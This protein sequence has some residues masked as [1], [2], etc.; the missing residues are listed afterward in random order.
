MAEIKLKH[1]ARLELHIAIGRSRHDTKWKN[2]TVTWTQLLEKVSETVR[3]HE[4]A[5][6]YR[7]MGKDDQSQIK[8]I[9]GFVG[10]VLKDGRRKNGFVVSRSIVTLDADFAPADFWDDVQ[11]LTTYAVAAYST[12]K[13]TP[14]HPRL[15]FLIPLNR[16]VSP[17]EYEAIARYI[18]N[19]LGIDYFDDTTYEPTRLMYWP[20]TS[21]D[22]D[23]FFEYVDAPI[24][25][26]DTVLAKYTDWKDTSNWPESSRCKGLRR[27]DAEKQGDPLAKTGLIGAFCRTYT[28]QDAIATFL[29]DA[30]TE[31][32]TPGRYTYVNG[33]TAAGLVVYEDKF[34]YSNHA[35]DPISG[36]L[37]NAFDLVRIHKFGEADL[38]AKEG[39]PVNKLPSWGKMMELAGSDENIRQTIG[40]EKL[41]RAKEDFGEEFQTTDD[42]AWLKKLKTNKAGGY[43]PTIGNL[44]LILQN[45]ANLRAIKGRDLFRDRCAVSGTLPW[46]REGDYWTDIDD[47]GLRDYIE[48]VYG[49]EAKGKLLDALALVFEEKSY[50]PVKQFIES[51][52]WDGKPR[53]ET[54]LIDYLGA[55]DSS[56]VRAV[57]RKTLVAAIARIYSPGC[58]FDYMLTIVGPQGH[59]KTL[60]V[61]KLAGEWFSNSI[62]EI[63]GKE[64]YEAL[65]GAWIVE[66]GELAA[67]KK[68]D[69]DAIK[70]YISKTEDTYRKAYAR[71]V[72]IN[73]RRCVFIGT[74]N[75]SAFLED[76]TGNRRFWVVDTDVKKRT[77]VPWGPNG[78]TDDEVHQ[79]WAEALELYQNGENIMELTEEELAAARLEQE[80]HTSDD[81]R[82]GIIEQYLNTPLPADWETKTEIERAQYYAGVDAFKG[83]PTGQPRTKV[84]ALEVWVECLQRGDKTGLTKA[85]TRL[86]NNALEKLGWVKSE[87]A[88]R[89]GPYGVQRGFIK[90]QE[91]EN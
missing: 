10:G 80:R 84:C 68:S 36:Q 50:H 73:R 23:F 43:E 42:T 47:A 66:M 37:C 29:P 9:G 13:H 32:S 28:I 8:D 60:L 35:T 12:H 53:V 85:E 31:C 76:D 38:E 64:S 6:E 89:F 77:K 58:K 11:L 22:A 3:T 61:Q 86:I 54:L 82:I 81:P 51:A 27:K 87:K 19:E 5:T 70:N 65:D 67:L 79:V 55:A 18:A 78:L 91:E 14:E 48:S 17:E 44:K 57:T 41:Q 33:S 49:I 56:Y 1:G 52:I 16:D 74:T 63:R 7:K 4:T 46:Q 69:R 88:M 34:A 75:E 26:A 40:E 30:Y 71:N 39:T 21:K 25:D 72:T 15:R 62:T 24:L 90:N 2:K 20:S 45:D 59:G 83:A